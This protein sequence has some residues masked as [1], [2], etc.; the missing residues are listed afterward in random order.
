VIWATWRMHR[1]IY[2]AAI[3]IAAAFAVWLIVTG[4]ME[5]H[6]WATFTSHR[7]STNYPGSSEAC[8]NSLSASGHFSSVN[9][10]LC[11]ALPV[12]L[13]LVL[14][15]PLVAGEFQQNTNR[16]AWT[17]SITKTRWLLSKIVVGTLVTVGIVGAF[18]P[19]IW[20]W[21]DAAQRGDH[22]QPSNF[23]ISGFVGVSYAL[24]ALMLGVA[25]GALIR[26]IGWA[27][28]VGLPIFAL[29]RLGVRNYIRPDL[30]PPTVVTVNAWA[31]VGN[32][33][34]YL[35]A[36]FVP[37][38]SSAPAS[39]QAWSSNDLVMETCQD[40]SNA[41]SDKS[42]HSGSHCEKIHHVHYVMQFQPPSHFWALQAA[43]SGIFLGLACGLLALSL[44]AVRRWRT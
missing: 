27:F 24:F 2:F 16:M 32:T 33:D 1:S 25:L 19:L 28:A 43:E 39:G 20:W 17:Q 9:A 38:G 41:G 12:I 36:G 40:G 18:A 30:V 37:I 14:G 7:C 22:I 26:R 21:T 8:M 11:G 5:Q 3:G 35:N 34:W 13:G 44:L 42:L 29:V 23:D 4:T 15:A 31:P 6:A 10:A